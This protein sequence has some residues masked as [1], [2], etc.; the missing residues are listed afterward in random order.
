M[1]DE[2]INAQKREGKINKTQRYNKFK[3]LCDF[4]F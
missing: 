3:T 4:F 2:K 1:V